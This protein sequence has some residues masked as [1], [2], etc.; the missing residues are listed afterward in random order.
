M[1]KTIE[2]LAA[3]IS[4]LKVEQ[5]SGKGRLPNTFSP[6][7]PNPFRKSN[8]QLQI[9]QRGKEVGEEQKVKAPFQ[10]V[11]MEEEQFE[12][13]D[14]IHCMEDKG[15]AAFLTLVAYKESLLRDQTS[16]KWNREAVLQT[17]VHQR[18]NLRSKENNVKENPAQKVVVPT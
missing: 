6:R 7:N 10:N 13:E 16:Q 4:K 18:Y 5:G 9:I 15:S 2:S 8:E 3:E 11:V 14:E 17:D 1:T 12:E